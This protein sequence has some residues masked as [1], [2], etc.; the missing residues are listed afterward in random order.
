LEEAMEIEGLKNSSYYKTKRNVWGYI[1]DIYYC[2][3]FVRYSR[4]F[5]LRGVKWTVQIVNI[6]WQK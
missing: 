3:S 1:M 5:R 6:Q 2:S 4:N